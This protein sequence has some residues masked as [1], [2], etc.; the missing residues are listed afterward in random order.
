MLSPY[1]KLNKLI[2]KMVMKGNK[3]KNETEKT[4]RRE[5]FSFYTTKLLP[6]IKIVMELG[7]CNVSI[8]PSMYLFACK[9]KNSVHTYVR[10]IVKG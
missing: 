5:L 6:T 7:I 9:R 8:Y 10:T 4:K 1:N 3:K 2:W